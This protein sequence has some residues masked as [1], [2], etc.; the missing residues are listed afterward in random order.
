MTAETPATG[1]TDAE[2][3]EVLREVPDWG[4]PERVLRAVGRVLAARAKPAPSGDEREALTLTDEHLLF[5]YL[6]EYLNANGAQPEVIGYDSDDRAF[7]A[8][9]D[10]EGGDCVGLRVCV[11]G[12]HEGRAE[13][14][15]PGEIEAPGQ[16]EVSS[17]RYPIRITDRRTDSPGCDC[18][19]LC[20][21][22][23]TCPGGMLAGLPGSGCSRTDDWPAVAAQV[24]SEQPPPFAP[25][26]TDSPAPSGAEA[27]LAEVERRV[28]ALPRKVSISGGD[29]CMVSIHDVLRE[30]R[31]LS[32]SAGP[33]TTEGG[34]ES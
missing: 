18:T 5:S 27:A 23:P 4:P 12:P 10:E 3:A 11:L 20:S 14:S 33:D 22:G 28:K 24:E 17:L 25:P 1:L 6:D 15:A 7:F 29:R 32:P 2:R 19:E 30:L 16:G 26:S 8:W 13:V 34:G 21:M 9:L 31:A